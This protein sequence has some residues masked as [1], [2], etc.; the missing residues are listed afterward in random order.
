MQSGGWICKDEIRIVG[1]S[2]TSHI[3]CMPRGW[4]AVAVAHDENNN[5]EIDRFLVPTEAYGFSNYDVVPFGSP[6]YDTARFQLDVD[7]LRI[8]IP[9]SFHPTIRVIG[10]PSET[11]PSRD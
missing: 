11:T 7:E 1:K 6:N 5:D 10:T 9:L 3:L 2:A 4:Y 8:T